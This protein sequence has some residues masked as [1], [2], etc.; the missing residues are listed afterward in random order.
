MVWKDGFVTREEYK[1]VQMEDFDMLDEE[2]FVEFLQR[3]LRPLHAT[4]ASLALR[5]V[6]CMAHVNL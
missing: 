6:L 1:A 5:F 4:C 3:V 2:E